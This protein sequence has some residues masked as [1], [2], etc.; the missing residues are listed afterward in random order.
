MAKATICDKHQK[1]I[2]NPKKWY[3]IRVYGPESTTYGDLQ[4]DICE[5]ALKEFLDWMGVKKQR[6]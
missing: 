1:V 2:E 4:F 6:L 3:I 5:D